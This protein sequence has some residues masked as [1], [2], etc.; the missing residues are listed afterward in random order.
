MERLSRLEARDEQREK[1]ICEIF[2][3]LDEIKDKLTNRPTWAT[4]LILTGLVT[5]SVSLIIIIVT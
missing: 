4:A 2:R 3:K 5:L 1:D